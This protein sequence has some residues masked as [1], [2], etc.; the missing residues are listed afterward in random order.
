[1]T[2]WLDFKQAENGAVDVLT[3]SGKT[4]P[5][6]IVIIALG[7]RPDTDV[8]EDRRPDNRQTRRDTR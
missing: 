5:A 2:A 3:K 4:Y 7:V 6:D 8:G 1:M